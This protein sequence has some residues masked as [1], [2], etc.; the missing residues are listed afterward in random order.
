MDHKPRL[1]WQYDSGKIRYSAELINDI[2]VNRLIKNYLR[3]GNHDHNFVLVGPKGIGK[4]LFLNLKS[5]LYRNDS[6]DKGLL[7]YPSSG[8]LC[9]NL[10][11]DNNQLSKKDL[12]RFS[13]YSIWAKIW[14]LVL[15]IIACQVNHVREEEDKLLIDLMENNRSLSTLITT[16]LMNRNMLDKYLERLRTLTQKIERI[17][18]GICI[19]I[20][21][22]DQALGQFLTD[23]DKTDFD[24]MRVP[25][26]VE[27]WTGAQ[28]GL[29]AAIY[30]INRHNSHIKIFSTIRSEAFICLDDQMK[31]NY[32][33]Y[34]TSL[35]YTKDEVKLIFEKN[36]DLMDPEEYVCPEADDKVERF[37]GVKKVG[38]TAAKFPSGTYRVEKPF[39]FLYRH[40]FGRPREM[41]LMGSSLYNYVVGSPGY[42]LDKPKD[43]VSKIRS[44]V[45]KVSDEILD[46]YLNEII[47]KFDRSQLNQF[48]KV[49]QSNVIP[50]D[51]ILKE[52]RDLAEH[53]FSI[54]LL[55]FTQKTLNGK[56]NLLQKFLPAAEYSY[57][58]NVT[59]PNTKFFVTHPC[60]DKTLAKVLDL[61]YYNSFNIIGPNKKFV[62]HPEYAKIY[63]V[64]FS[65][66]NEERAYVEEVAKHLN[67]RDV[68][69]FYDHFNKRKTWGMD[70]NQF[71]GDVYNSY[72]KFCVIF[73]SENYTKKKWT[74]VELNHAIR[75]HNETKNRER[76]LLPVRFDESPID[77]IDGLGYMDTQENTPA[78]L[79]ELIY[80]LI[81]ERR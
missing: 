69:V 49:I 40:S 15:S 70:L 65:Y 24:D 67:Q 22:I 33:N 77:G 8:Q 62:D 27:V 39:D 73:V 78:E 50:S 53:Y 35:K 42:D 38:H 10:M 60:L 25:P 75:R 47:P 11:L 14:R 2:Y 28:M 57:K 41:V 45:N 3:T 18:N 16:I 48:I 64:A 54:G 43:R 81:Y 30:E 74:L 5:Y 21:N 56:D 63:D 71:L 72:S 31:L 37:L 44:E 36:I 79:A 12:L 1:P 61:R 51:Y 34:T 59:L 66:A 6:H 80:D 19:F 55:G 58:E 68:K 4:T 26:A 52:Q 17:N 13:G 9:E 32:K 76:Y 23:Y 46:N 20:D 7:F 29:L